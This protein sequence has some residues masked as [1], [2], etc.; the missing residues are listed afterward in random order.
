[1]ST[2]RRSA[3]YP[4]A[5]AA[6]LECRYGLN[7]GRRQ[8]QWTG[9]AQF[10][11]GLRYLEITFSVIIFNLKKSHKRQFLTNMFFNS[12]F[13]HYAPWDS[14]I[15]WVWVLALTRN[16]AYGDPAA[17]TL[18]LSDVVLKSVNIKERL[19]WLLP[20][21]VTKNARKNWLKSVKK[22]TS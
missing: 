5:A 15:R 2:P 13:L 12:L 20:T 7:R 1:M 11:D 4:C 3:A 14:R 8:D 19:T 16:V 10:L 18:R 22:K 17:D 21:T 6:S 9:F